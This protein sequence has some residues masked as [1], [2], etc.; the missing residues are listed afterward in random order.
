M[1]SLNK[2]RLI[3]WHLFSNE[4]A[5]IDNVTF[6]TGANG[7]GK[8]TIID[9][10]QIV[11]LGDTT[12]RNFNKAANDK[13][14]RTLISYLKGDT[15]ETV[16]GEVSYIRPGRFSSYIALQFFDDKKQLPFTLGVAF[17]VYDDETQDHSFFFVNDCFPSNDFIKKDNGKDRPCTIKEFTEFVK[18]N[19][20]SGEYK[21]FESN[22]AYQ[23]FL[24]DVFGSLPEKYFS[25]FKKAVSFSPIT[26]ISSF[27]TE[28]VCDIDFK[29]DIEP[30]KKNI[31]QY[32]LLELEAK[33]IKDKIVSL[34]EIHDVF[35]VLSKAK[36]DA[37]LS[38]YLS[39]RVLSESS[40][41]LI[42][43][44]KHT[45][46]ENAGRIEEIISIINDYNN[47]IAALERKKEVLLAQKIGSDNYSASVS[48][49][50]QKDAIDAKINNIKS[51]YQNLI[52]S[53]NKYNFPLKQNIGEFLNATHALSR[54]SLN[55]NIVTRIDAFIEKSHE[56]LKVI[57][58]TDD[59][60][61]KNTLTKDALKAYQKVTSEYVRSSN[62]I[63]S[64]LENALDD[65]YVNLSNLNQDVS[66]M[67]GG[68]KPFNAQFL[69]VKN[70]LERELVK[71]HKDAKVQIYCDLVDIT[72]KRWTKAIEVAIYSQKFNLFVNEEYFEEA[73]A[74]LKQILSRN[75]IRVSLVDS[76]RLIEKGFKAKDD[77]VATVISTN[78]EGARAYTNYL[79]GGIYKCET[80]Q[81]A[82]DCGSGLLPDCTG[83]RSY[84]TWYLNKRLA[85][86]EYIGTVLGQNAL[87]AKKSE[88]NTAKELVNTL[89]ALVEAVC[90]VALCQVMSTNECENFCQVISSNES[91][92]TS[93]SKEK[94]SL[95]VDLSSNELKDVNEIDAK[96]KEIEADIAEISARKENLIKEQ[97]SLESESKTLAEVTIPGLINSADNL[98]AGLSNKYTAEFIN[99]VAEPFFAK[100]KATM[101]LEKIKLDAEQQRKVL[102][103]KIGQIKSK[104]FN[105]RSIYVAANNLYYAS[106]DENSNKE[107]DDELA[108]LTD[109]Q[110][111]TYE[112]KIF[113]AH[114]NAI[115][116]FKD[117]FIYKLRTSIETVKSQID[118]LNA[119]LKDVKFGKD[120][121]RFIVTPNKDFSDYYEMITSDLLLNPQSGSNDFVDQY[122]PVM[123]ELF[124][125]IS[126][127][128]VDDAVQKAQ[129]IQNIEKFTDYRT[130]L[131]FDLLVK[132]GNFAIESSLSR[133][134]KKQSGG[135]TQTPFYI[136]I[137][138]SFAQMYRVKNEKNNDTMRLVI[139]DE[140]FSKMDSTR[141]KEV[142]ALIKS[143]GLQAILSTPSEKIRD[144]ANSVDL[145]LVA[146]HDNK[147]SRS[148]LD[149]YKEVK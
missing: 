8:S 85:D 12:S 116:E 79:L 109:Y 22:V 125:L 29:I 40:V 15:G 14:A 16:N 90:G 56:T 83:Y 139:F 33:K 115:K 52:R 149:R 24:K 95:D 51:A 55:N 9:A 113:V 75:F 121:Y 47:D 76:E 2:L 67:S 130:Y 11:L 122:G 3:N 143:F 63:V 98:K 133:T 34:N 38:E 89:K 5:N 136:S 118:E 102:A 72:D 123:E 105:L 28:F 10:I 110:L 73:D 18:K 68:S 141:I 117:D 145:I 119:A 53:L 147:K 101:T 39:E 6:L 114:E 100:A 87:E 25:L 45:I 88:Q 77:S 97:G 103:I 31:E 71:L 81:E 1:I 44:H 74:I 49:S 20:A 78:H 108:L 120:S 30:M 106:T 140:A 99:E 111:P 21:F 46:E 129:I 112:Q 41:V 64:V 66:H 17:D 126:S 92:L 93:L 134:F 57:T 137:L 84:S 23:L 146:M 80:F 43:K 19:Y 26:N 61:N 144:L 36:Q 82:R 69:A 62:T 60:I 27:I 132:R 7:T 124:G 127:S 4:T 86:V 50:A 54:E 91:E 131:N 148:Y 42:Q 96:I 107:F 35:L 58:H 65:A 104:L 94:E 138:A 48:I 70:E 142:V 13:S 59:L 135:E 128:N 37:L 32:K